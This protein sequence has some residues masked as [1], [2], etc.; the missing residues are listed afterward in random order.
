MAATKPIP[1]LRGEEKVYFEEAKNGRLVYQL[2]RD[3]AQRI[4]YPRTVCTNCMS[5]NLEYVASAGK[6]TIYSF[7][8][9]HVPGHP[10]F[11]DDVPYTVV[12]VDLEEG[13][14]VLADLVDCDPDDVKVGMSVEVLFEAV[15]EDFTV[16]RFRP[17]AQ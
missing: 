16:P 5:E 15:T 12:L 7:T 9:L 11:A 2:C 3:C 14:R 1:T 10:E 8:T 17:S 6:G 4:F 13:V